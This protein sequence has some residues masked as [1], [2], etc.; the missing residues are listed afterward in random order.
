[1]KKTYLITLFI[2]LLEVLRNKPQKKKNG[3]KQ[4]CGRYSRLKKKKRFFFRFF[5]QNIK[6]SKKIKRTLIC[7]RNLIPHTIPKFLVFIGILLKKFA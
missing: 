1:M 2:G 3:Q 6:I 5:L 4:Y 7:S